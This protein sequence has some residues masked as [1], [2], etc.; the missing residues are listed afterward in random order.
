MN[1]F[2]IKNAWL[3]L[4]DGEA[5]EV[6]SFSKE[7]MNF[8]DKS[9][10]E[11][12]CAN[13]IIRQAKASGFINIEDVISGKNQIKAGTKVYAQ[14]NGKSVALFVL[15]EERLEK[16]FKLVGAHIDSPRIDLK[17]NPLYEDANMA[18]FKTHYYGGIK[19]YQWATIPLS[20][21]GTAYTK[22]G[23][24]IDISIGDSEDEP[25]FFINDLLIHLS[26][27]QMQLKASDVIKGEQ[28]NVVVGSRPIGLDKDGKE[29]KDSIKDNVLKI[30]GE[31]YNLDERTFFTAEFELV[32]SGISREVGFD[33][34]MIAA[35]GHDDRV[36]AFSGLKSILAVENPKFMACA[37]FT[38][39]EEVGS[40][41]N[42]G[43][44]SKFFENTIAELIN[45]EGEYSDL[46]VRRAFS[47][48][49][50]LSADV[51]CCLDP[52]FPEVSDK[53]NN[54]VLGNGVALTKYTGSKGKSGCNDANAEFVY[55]V[56]TI[57]DAN[58]IVWQIGELGKV[59]Q[60]GG[61]T[62]AYILANY[63]AQVIDCGTPVLS[64][65]APYEIISKVDAYMTYKG[66]YNFLK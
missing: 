21:Y 25:V 40:Q 44:Q 6:E 16:G 10:T 27:D 64:M 56:A 46:K 19:K 43:M 37:V 9:K 8:I 15:G 3:R 59:D 23:Q 11:R 48:A 33:K 32:P 65:H 26:S 39:K 22:D 35:Y 36:C 17:P 58:D 41:G 31:K 55:E 45:L 18:L 1:K 4:K 63:G 7:Y 29:K 28:L 50:V 66:Y 60:G 30:L 57:F 51:N 47:N 61:G 5:F 49:K 34:S 54:A 13:E 14:N 53:N 12:V 42:T 24:K 38:D 20:L 52:T 2:E 62:I